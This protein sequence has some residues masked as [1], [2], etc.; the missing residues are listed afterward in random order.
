M[1]ARPV[2]RSL[3]PRELDRPRTRVHDIAWLIV[4]VTIAMIAGLVAPVGAATADTRVPVTITPTNAQ[5]SSGNTLSYVAG[6]S[7]SV[8]N[9]CRGVTVTI[10]APAG[11]AGAGAVSQPTSAYVAST[12]PG[13]GN[14]VV[15]SFADIP[16]GNTVDIQVNWPTVDYTTQPGSQTVTATASFPGEIGGDSTATTTNQLI[17]APHPTLDKTGPAQVAAGSQIVYSI[18]ASNTNSPTRPEGDLAMVNPVIVDNL[19]AGVTFV[20]ASGGGVYNPVNRTVTWTLT[21]PLTTQISR[22]VTVSVPAGSPLVGHQ[23]VN[24]ATVTGT[25]LGGG[26]PVSASGTA[27]TAIVGSGGPGTPQLQKTGPSHAND[28]GSFLWSLI[29]YNPGPNSTTLRIDDLD[30][31]AGTDVYNILVGD[32][33]PATLVVHYSDGSTATFTVPGNDQVRAVAKPGLRVTGVSASRLAAPGDSLIVRLQFTADAAGVPGGAGGPVTNCATETFTSGSQTVTS[34]QKCATTDIGVRT[35]GGSLIKSTSQ[36]P[37]QPGGTHVWDL[38]ITSDYYRQHLSPLAPK[39]IDL[40][41]SQLSYVDGSF[42]LAP[43]QPAFCPT[44]ADFVVTQVSGFE[45]A[46]TA[47]DAGLRT[48]TA[49]I[50]TAKPGITI[51]ADDSVCSYLLTTQVKAATTQGVYGQPSSGAY[52]GNVSYLLDAAGAMLPGIDQYIG[53]TQPDSADVARDGNTGQGIWQAN[54]DFAVAQS[55]QATVSKSVRGDLDSSWVGSPELAGHRSDTA[56]STP[57]GSVSYQLRMG[58][59]GNQPIEHLVAYDLLPAPGSPGVTDGRYA[60]HPLF[61]GYQFVPTLTGPIDPGTSGA[62][63]TY[64]TKTDP[65]RPEMDATGG[66]APFYC[67]GQVDPSF[68]AAAAVTNWAAVRAVRFDF[69]AHV[70]Q[71]GESYPF[72]FSMAVPATDASGAALTDGETTWNKVGVGASRLTASGALIPLLPTEAPWVVDTVRVPAITPP[73]PPATQSA[74]GSPTVSPTTSTA[75][76]PASGPTASVPPQVDALAFTGVAGLQALCWAAA[77]LLG[78]LGLTLAGRMRRVRRRRY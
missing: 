6:L 53:T 65:C 5:V 35:S 12:A 78:G 11:A 60:D 47:L 30:I 27:T 55:F 62:T 36:V 68:V 42:T 20:S 34:P 14:S 61:G 66:T 52:Q 44:G 51:P 38:T 74:P 70:F 41:P 77:L 3:R 37:V 33:E 18:A 16:A 9:G 58:N 15:V 63:V 29:G 49:V 76:A 26:A 23:V 28:G 7:C 21:A 40:I 45:S 57:A 10:T 59:T 43:G 64:S 56:N 32:G 46:N 73:S 8:P 24:S 17:A 2:H 69:G 50:A 54:S 22:T 1:F 67:E 72:E 48:R 31:P 75:V 39:L 13:P 25:P 19:P 71:P 4:V